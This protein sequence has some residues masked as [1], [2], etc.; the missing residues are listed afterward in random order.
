PESSRRCAA[1]EV[2]VSRRNVVKGSGPPCLP[3]QQQ[4]MAELGGAQFARPLKYRIEYRLELARRS[5]NYAENFRGRCL[6]LPSDAQ[7][8]RLRLHLLEQPRVLDGDHGLVRKGIDELDLA[9][10]ERANFGATN[11][12]RSDCLAGVD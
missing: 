10:G 1:P 9:F 12:D 11:D 7:I 2:C 4:E 5:T 8:A 3:I 6:A